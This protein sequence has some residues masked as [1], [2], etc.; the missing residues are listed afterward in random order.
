MQ[1]TQFFEKRGIIHTEAEKTCF[2]REPYSIFGATS[3]KDFRCGSC[4]IKNRNIGRGIFL[5]PETMETLETV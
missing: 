2:E 3:A 5:F 1:K 4:G